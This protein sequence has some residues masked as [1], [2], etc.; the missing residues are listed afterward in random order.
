MSTTK[1]GVLAL[2][3]ASLAAAVVQA[4]PPS[5]WSAVERIAP[6]TRLRVVESG[7]GKPEVKGT[8]VRAGADTIVI[9]G[10]TGETSL[11]RT[12]VK[13]LQ[14]EA[15]HRRVRQG[16][17]SLGVGAGIGLGVGVAVCPYCRNEGTTRYE[18]IGAALGAGIGAIGFL[19]T[20]YQ[21]VYKA[22]KR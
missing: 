11:D 6:G 14:V 5:N 15:P 19:F 18:G 12:A 20:P 1:L 4:A 17:I 9:N 13:I 3:A 10:K 8:L 16:L 2:A 22:P 7:R 21:T